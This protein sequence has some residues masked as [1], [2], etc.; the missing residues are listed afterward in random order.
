MLRAAL[1]VAARDKLGFLG[2]DRGN[3]NDRQA[4]T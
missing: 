3:L 4:E 2:S 1:K